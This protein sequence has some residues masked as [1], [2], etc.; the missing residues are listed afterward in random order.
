[1]KLWAWQNSKYKSGKQIF[2]SLTLP[3]IL[4]VIF[5]NINSMWIH[6]DSM[7]SGG[8]RFLN[9]EW[10]TFHFATYGPFAFLFSGL[11]NGMLFPIGAAIGSWKTKVAFEEA[12]RTNHVDVLN[13]SFTNFSLLINFVLI[14][15]SLNLTFTVSPILKSNF[16]SS[17]IS[18]KTECKSFL[19]FTIYNVSIYSSSSP[20]H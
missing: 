19:L 9:G 7:T 2:S 1:M 10:S 6:P 12:Y 3:L 8:L 11:M 4:G 16:K 18:F 5:L 15:F 13:I 17:G 14:I 20:S